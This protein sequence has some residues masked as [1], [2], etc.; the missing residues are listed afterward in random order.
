MCTAHPTETVSSS[1]VSCVCLRL[2]TYLVITCILSLT[3]DKHSGGFSAHLRALPCFYSRVFPAFPCWKCDNVWWSVF[4]K[5]TA[6]G[7]ILVLHGFPEL[8]TD[9]PDSWYVLSM[10]CTWQINS[11]SLLAYPFLLFSFSFST[12]FQFLVPC[13]R[14]SWLM[15]G[16]ER[17]LE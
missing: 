7:P 6:V 16:F 9:T 5:K 8:F 11:L 3:G 12:F 17:T 10:L 4:T 13:C 2:L 1:A 15:T 14:L